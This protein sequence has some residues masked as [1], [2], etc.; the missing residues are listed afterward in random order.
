MVTR[1]SLLSILFVNIWQTSMRKRFGKKMDR[2]DQHK[3][4]VKISKGNQ[5]PGV[6]SGVPER[7][8]VSAAP[9]TSVVLL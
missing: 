5:N 4:S 3:K 1:D 9:V 2:C 6:N 8:A 7:P